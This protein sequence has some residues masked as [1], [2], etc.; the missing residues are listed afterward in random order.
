MQNGKA[1]ANKTKPA[2]TSVNRSVSQPDGEAADN[3]QEVNNENEADAHH[4]N[5]RLKTAR[6][7]KDRARSDDS[8]KTNGVS[9][10]I[11]GNRTENPAALRPT[12]FNEQITPQNGVEKSSNDPSSQGSKIPTQQNLNKA[13]QSKIAK[14]APQD[15]PGMKSNGQKVLEPITK[16]PN[17][18]KNGAPLPRSRDSGG[19]DPDKKVSFK[20]KLEDHSDLN[21]PESNEDLDLLSQHQLHSGSVDKVYPLT[22]RDPPGSWKPGEGVRNGSVT[23]RKTASEPVLATRDGSDM[24]DDVS[25][26]DRYGSGRDGFKY[27]PTGRKF[28]SKNGR[29]VFGSSTSLSST[30]DNS[31]D[32]DDVFN[33]VL[34]VRP[35][36]PNESGRRDKFVADFPG[37][38]QVAVN[39]AGTIRNFQFNVVFEPDAGQEDVFENCGIKKLVEA[40]MNGYTCTAFA[41]G[42][43]GSGKTHTMTGPPA[44]FHTEGV[45]P[46][47]KMYGLMQRSFKYLF[48]LKKKQ[49]AQKIV[50]A[51]FLEVYN[52]QV[53]DLLNNSQRRYLTVRWSKNKGFYVE[54]LFT[55]ECQTLDDLMAVLEEEHIGFHGVLLARDRGLENL[56]ELKKKKFSH[57]NHLVIFENGIQS[58]PPFCSRDVLFSR[59]NEINEMNGKRDQER[60][61]N[62]PGKK[63][64][65]PVHGNFQASWPA[66]QRMLSRETTHQRD[67][68][69]TR[70]RSGTVPSFSSLEPRVR[71]ASASVQHYSPIPEKPG[72]S[73]PHPVVQKQNN[74]LDVNDVALNREPEFRRHSYDYVTGRG[75]QRHQAVYRARHYSDYN[76]KHP[77]AQHDE[78]RLSHAHSMNDNS[79]VINQRPDVDQRVNDQRPEVSNTGGVN[80]V[81]IARA[82]ELGKTPNK[83]HNPTFAS[84]RPST[85]T[86]PNG[87][88]LSHSAPSDV[89]KLDLSNLSRSD[90][91]DSFPRYD[92]DPPE[93]DSDPQ[94]ELPSGRHNLPTDVTHVQQESDGHHTDDNMDEPFYINKT[95]GLPPI[96][97]GG[98]TP[99][100]EESQ[101]DETGNVQYVL[102][103]R[104]SHELSNNSGDADSEGEAIDTDAEAKYVGGDVYVFYLQTSEGELVGPL[105]FD[106]EDVQIGLPVPSEVEANDQGLRNRQ[107]GSHGLNE[108]SSRSHSIL[109]V[110]VDSETQAEPEDDNL[111]V[112]KRGKL[113]FVDLAGS[114][115]VRD[116]TSTGGPGMVES[117]S[118]NKSLLVLGNC[119]SH[120]CDSKK[121]QGHIP[122]RDSKLTKLLSDSL[123]GNGITLMIACITPS[124]SN[125]TE[126]L[127]TLRYASRAKKIKT[128]PTVKMDPR[129]KLILSLKKEVRILRQEN[130]YLRQQLDF[131][132]KP[133]GQ[134]QKENDEKFRKFMK[135]QT[136]KETGLYDMLQEYMI[137][138]EALRAENSEMHS[139]KESSRREQQILYRENETLT[140]RVEELERLMSENPGTWALYDPRRHDGYGQQDISPR[141]SPV[142]VGYNSPPNRSSV[143]YNSPPNRNV[144]RPIGVSGPNGVGPPKNVSPVA[145]NQPMRPPHRLSDHVTRPAPRP[146]EY[147]ET[148]YNNE[149]TSPRQPVVARQGVVS[150][151]PL[152]RKLSQVSQ[153]ELNELLRKDLEDLDGEIEQ[154]TRIA[155]TSR[156]VPTANHR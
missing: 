130:H 138:N 107:T 117:N 50:K 24:F 20:E 73:K 126:T 146:I 9:K 34:R 10:S 89:F 109:T 119:I 95:D 80:Q 112:T 22:S 111:Y 142:N 108:F 144:F 52:E 30:T 77:F 155:H 64:H 35:L 125:V 103:N 97:G 96:Y 11:S 94:D 18:G 104:N 21:T 124:S 16:A 148:N 61:T 143:G 39:N 141:G 66:N 92:S 14:L 105:Q 54:N 23:W 115:K 137:E 154:Q 49:G 2:N 71:R 91:S 129:E 127:N 151:R 122:Y 86:N 123:G 139:V 93:Y 149:R 83:D 3:E 58:E 60:P 84:L 13:N 31:D 120:L 98:D 90:S 47:P 15:K 116:S 131:P 29:S 100:Q 28:T 8:P 118:I 132:A 5:P 67:L 43:T 147:V 65:L 106:V 153:T 7:R 110:T 136:Q 102:R 85:T 152:D 88:N 45:T 55:V 1:K 72:V 48:Q 150:H 70:A 32:S 76:V 42:Q 26:V 38:G 145:H 19:S 56:R 69:M 59:G 62:Y 41:F 74:Y 12:S 6:F 78:T 133:K 128:K 81:Y 25:W 17:H 101:T 87:Y 114:E 27:E 140:R 46:D 79:S 68:E 37:E 134:L 63:R 99:Q 40:A 33:V 53:I 121:R 57:K 36:N 75:A 113:S 156:G 44:Q 82:G 135:E 4:D 51:S